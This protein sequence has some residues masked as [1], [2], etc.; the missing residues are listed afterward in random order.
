MKKL[1]LLLPLPLLTLSV[2][3]CTGTVPNPPQST[4][5][6]EHNAISA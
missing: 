1:L 6:T 2:A 5:A 3:S 4:P